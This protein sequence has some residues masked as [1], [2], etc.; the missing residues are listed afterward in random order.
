MPT[1][2]LTRGCNTGA[3]NITQTDVVTSGEGITL[4]EDVTTGTEGLLV[5]FAFTKAKLQSI[6]ITAD[7]A[8]TVYTNATGGVRQIETATIVGTITTAGN[9][10]I[11]V[12]ASGMSGSPITLSVAVALG[13]TAATVATK[14]RTA[15]AANSTIA[16][17]FVIG[18]SGADVVLTRAVVA[19]N[20][21]TMNLS[22]ANGTCLGL[23][24]ESTSAN[25]RAG[26]AAG[27]FQDTIAL[28]A[29]Q[30]YIWST[31]DAPFI[32]NP[33]GGNVTALYVNNDS[34][35]DG[36]LTIN[37]IVDPT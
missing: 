24:T 5:A 22:S 7:E 29:G 1:N 26:V 16:A 8:M 18:G 32:A 27:A 36:T 19:A 21:S 30:A 25:T 15:L 33:F 37:A 20:D 3:S 34:G 17:F 13:D 10:T 14:V 12:T 2:R 31:G 28:A 35:S 23:T 9:A 11:V 6:Y 4:G